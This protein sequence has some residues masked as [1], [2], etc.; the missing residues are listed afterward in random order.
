[1]WCCGQV[2]AT[3]S[4][5]EAATPVIDLN[6]YSRYTEPIFAAQQKAKY[7]FKTVKRYCGVSKRGEKYS[8][9]KSA[10]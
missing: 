3:L 2:D 1:M 7:N 9:Q 10:E 8:F 6:I 4:K 5:R